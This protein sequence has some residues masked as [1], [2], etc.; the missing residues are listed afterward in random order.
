MLKKDDKAEIALK[1]IKLK[2]DIR[3]VEDH[4]EKERRKIRKDFDRKISEVKIVA[5]GNKKDIKKL[6]KRTD[7]NVDNIEK[8]QDYVQ[9]TIKTILALLLTVIL[10]TLLKEVFNF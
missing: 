7:D 2:G 9:W 6:Y 3:N 10:T 8:L 4:S 5:I 1:I